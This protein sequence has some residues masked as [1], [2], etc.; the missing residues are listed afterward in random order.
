MFDKR[1]DGGAAPD[2]ETRDGEPVKIISKEERDLAFLLHR[3]RDARRAG[4]IP[5]GIV[6]YS[7]S[8]RQKRKSY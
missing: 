7:R 1:R 3:L 2:R 4:S 8:F 6:R 5:L